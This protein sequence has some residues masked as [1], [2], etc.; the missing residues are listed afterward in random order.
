MPDVLVLCIDIKEAVEFEALGQKLDLRIKH[1]HDLKTAL[2]WLRLRRYDAA[3]VHAG[4][5]I[6]AQQELA[7]LLW[8]GN[9]IAP[10]LV[11]D[12]DPESKID[13]NEM[14]LYGAELVKGPNPLSALEKY[15]HNIKPEAKLEKE[16]FKV[17]VVED[18]DSPRDIICFYLESLGYPETKGFSSAKEAMAELEKDPKAYSCIVTDIRMPEISGDQFIEYVRQNPKLQHLPIVVLTAH[19]TI[20]CLIDCLKAGASGF[21]VKPPKKQ[22]LTRELA[23]AERILSKQ[24]NPRLVN[25]DEAEIVRNLVAEKLI[26]D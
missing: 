14:K 21:L 17:M 11:Y 20:D 3:L 13:K 12:L 2:T 16:N 1:T 10:F 25:V 15:F 7:G 23:R 24:W 9:S 4:T 26:E 6:E 19:G 18:L 8:E 5:P 22:D